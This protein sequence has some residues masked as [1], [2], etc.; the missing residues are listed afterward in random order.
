MIFVPWFYAHIN[1]YT[2]YQIYFWISRSMEMI[3]VSMDWE[4]EI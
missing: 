1:A 4:Q 3:L 2:N